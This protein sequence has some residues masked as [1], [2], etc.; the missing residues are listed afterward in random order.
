MI[1]RMHTPPLCRRY[2]CADLDTAVVLPT[3][4]MVTMTVYDFDT[5]PTGGYTESLQVP[6][7]PTAPLPHRRPAPPAPANTQT[8]QRILFGPIRT[9]SDLFGPIQTY[10]TENQDI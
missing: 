6:H 5:G 7:C 1:S 3:G 9:C 10:E 8:T 2:D 4:A